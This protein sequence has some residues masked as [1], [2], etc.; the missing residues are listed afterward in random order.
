[1]YIKNGT[2]AKGCVG[3]MT[4]PRQREYD[5]MEIKNESCAAL[6]RSLHRNMKQ[7]NIGVKGPHQM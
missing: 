2:K 7:G 5:V 4:N 1:M 3:K 6:L